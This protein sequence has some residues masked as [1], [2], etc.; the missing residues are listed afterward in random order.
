MTGQ[1]GAAV[2][3]TVLHRS[4]SPSQLV[5]AS[6]F[7][8]RGT[9]SRCRQLS[10]LHTVFFLRSKHRCKRR[11]VGCNT[12]LTDSETSVCGKVLRT[13]RKFAAARNFFAVDLYNTF[14]TRHMSPQIYCKPI[15]CTRSVLVICHSK[16]TESKVFDKSGARG[17]DINRVGRANVLFQFF[18]SAQKLE[19]KVTGRG[20]LCF[21][22]D[23]D[24]RSIVGAYITSDN[25]LS[26]RWRDIHQYAIIGSFA[27]S[28]SARWRYGAIDLRG[29]GMGGR[30]I[31]D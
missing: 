31:V 1:R 10:T 17:L 4:Q 30:A 6:V 12:R 25:R 11:T 9:L 23:T 3:V 20:I 18:E 22:S 24:L 2:A 14:N 16:D 19:E 28:S 8:L 27:R 21:E 7:C 5:R 29:T 15:P 26:Q 13:S